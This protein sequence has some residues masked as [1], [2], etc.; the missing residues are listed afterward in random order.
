MGTN[1]KRDVE[2]CGVLAGQLDSKEGIFKISTLII[3]KQKGTSNTVEML[4]EVEVYNLQDQRGLYPMGWI[5]THPSQTCFLSS[6]DV[7]TQ[8]AYQV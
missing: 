1:T 2:S 5:H 4:E 6:I 3:P 8:C 7:H